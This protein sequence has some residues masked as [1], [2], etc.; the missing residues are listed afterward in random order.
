MR[1]YG[2]VRGKPAPTP[3]WSDRLKPG[4]PWAELNTQISV[5]PD[6]W[7]RERGIPPER[8]RQEFARLVEEIREEAIRRA[9]AAHATL[10]PETVTPSLDR[11]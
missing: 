1:R 2:S 10:S 6:L 7:A 3:H 8:V 9:I 5:D 4:A 11:N